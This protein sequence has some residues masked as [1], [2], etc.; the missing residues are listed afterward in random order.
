MKKQLQTMFAVRKQMLAYAML[1]VLICGGFVS[2]AQITNYSRTVLSG[3]TYTQISG[4]TVINS[5]AQLTGLGSSD[6]DGGLVVT[7]PFTFTYDGIGYTQVTFC[8]NGWIGMG[9]QTSLTASQGRAPGSLFTSTVPNSTI[10]CWFGDGCANWSS[11]LGTAA[12]VHGTYG[13]GAYAEKR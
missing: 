9:N 10:G 7:L 3:L 13:T 12:M 2:K 1:L 8:T 11:G 4:G 5:N 6:D